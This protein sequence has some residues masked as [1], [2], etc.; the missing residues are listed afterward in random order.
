MEI[1]N[2]GR[3]GG[4]PPS[5]EQ[6]DSESARNSIDNHTLTIQVSQTPEPSVISLSWAE[7]PTPKARD[8]APVVAAVTAPQST[9]TGAKKFFGKLSRRKDSPIPRVAEP[10]YSPVSSPLKTSLNPPA[11]S[12][13]VKRNSLL[14]P[15]QPMSPIRPKDVIL[16]PAVLG[17]QPT[18]GP[19]PNPPQGRPT[20]YLWTV[21]KWL[22]GT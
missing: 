22:K 21:T 12:S 18:L 9:P 19:T 2:H 3:A 11:P 16:Q 15:D 14:L 8:F 4:G 17:I 6:P 10:S 13:P 7:N 5:V 1:W 20:A